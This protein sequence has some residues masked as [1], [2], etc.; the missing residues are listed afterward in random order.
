[1]FSMLNTLGIPKM[2]V[3]HHSVMLTV[4]NNQMRIFCNKNPADKS[5]K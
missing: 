3:Q 5:Y 4:N 1:M 2:Q